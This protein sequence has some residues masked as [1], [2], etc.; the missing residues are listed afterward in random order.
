VHSLADLRDRSAGYRADH[1]AQRT[2]ILEEYVPADEEWLVDGFVF[3]GELE[4][5]AL[6]RYS[7][8][9][10][11]VIADNLPFWTRRL[12]PDTDADAYAAAEP[13]VRAAL[14]ALGLRDGVFH[15]EL[16]HDRASGKVTF[17]ECAARRGGVLVHEEVQAK[18]NVDLCDAALLCALG[19]RPEPLVKVAPQ[20]V[21]STF[22]PGRPGTLVD[23]PTPDEVL[24][25]PDVRFVRLECPPGTRFPAT[26]NSTNQRVGQVMVAARS[27]E[28]LLR[29]LGEVREWFEQ[30]IAVLPDGATI[31]ELRAWQAARTPGVEWGDPLWD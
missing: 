19:H 2:F 22:L 18:F 17:G 30:R 3:D 5:F 8:P 4:F 12:A 23:C 9:C 29:R 6:G 26:V 20:V 27:E 13:V 10:L 24:A 15:M 16:F 25:L 7:Q 11:T 28:R 1:T 14:A 31:R 21:G